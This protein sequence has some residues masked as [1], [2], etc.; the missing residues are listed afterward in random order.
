MR[1]ILLSGAL[2]ALAFLPVPSWAGEAAGIR[3][4]LNNAR[5]NKLD[6]RISFV[7][8]NTLPSRIDAMSLE[9]VLFTKQGLVDQF[10]K[11]KTGVLASGKL[12]VKQFDLKNTKCT[13]VSKILINEI[14]A[15]KGEGLSP[16]SCLAALSTSS[17]ASIQLQL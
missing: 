5:Q 7:M 10:L 13:D 4:E 3:I 17:R 12:R 11:L 15:C 14:A 8:Q 1:K 9:V 6:C 16:S 2:C